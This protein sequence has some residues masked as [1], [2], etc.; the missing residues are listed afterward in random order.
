MAS[1]GVR[2][3]TVVALVLS[4]VVCPAGHAVWAQSVPTETPA[5]PETQARAD[6]DEGVRL[7][8]AQQWDAA[9]A[10]FER[11]R[12]RVDQPNTALNV[13]VLQRQ[14]G[15]L[16]AARQTLRA[17]L[18]M[19]QNVAGSD[20]ARDASLLLSLV[21][22]SIAT[23]SFSVEP[24]EATVLVDGATAPSPRAVELDPGVYTVTVRA[25]G[26]ADETLT[27]TLG[28]GERVAR[29]VRL[30][31][32]PAQV[33]VETTPPEADIYVN[34]A[35]LGRGAVRWQGA[36]GPLRLRATLAQHDPV[37]RELMV[38]PG[39]VR[40]EQLT[41]L[42]STRP[43]PRRPWLWGGIAIAAA[44]LAG[45]TTAILL[46]TPGSPTGDGG[47]TGTILNAQ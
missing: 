28:T 7:A 24:P 18:A 29:T 22:D 13:A 47:S 21:L 33:A 6:F 14:L 9:L 23:V 4:G 38:S 43:A 19:P 10:A 32:L 34:D 26:H 31:A 36:A 8:R 46:S 5:T 3:L 15:R 42:P 1:R 25:P 17:C 16:L 20:L 44:V 39:A 35:L 45:V 11:S 37:A 40:V 27:L 12:A 41:L 2:L 30:R